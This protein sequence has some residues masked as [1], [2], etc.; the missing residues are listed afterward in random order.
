MMTLDEFI[1]E[2]GKLIAQ[3][4]LAGKQHDRRVTDIPDLRMIRYYTTLGLLD[5]PQMSGREAR[6]TERHVLQILAI[7]A[8]Q[9]ASINLSEIQARLYGKSDQELEAI[10]KAFAQQETDQPEVVTWREILIEPGLK[11]LADEKWKPVLNEAELQQRVRAAIA[12]FTKK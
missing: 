7:K 5:R 6:Y 10:V 3:Y 11:F 8:L 1:D 9:V 12:V 2:I 4:G